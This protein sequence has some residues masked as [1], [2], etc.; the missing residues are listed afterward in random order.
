VIGSEDVQIYGISGLGEVAG[1]LQLPPP[2]PGHVPDQMA[3][4]WLGV[5][6]TP[7]RLGNLG[8]GQSAAYGMSSTGRIVGWA[9]NKQLYMRPFL[10]TAAGMRDLGTLGGPRG[11]ASAITGPWIAGN[12]ELFTKG[13]EITGH[14]TLW[15]VP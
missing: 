15:W 12:S 3:F 2:G 4:A 8:A 1:T 14:A 11:S 13:R 9:H 5:E 10:W 6:M 7:T